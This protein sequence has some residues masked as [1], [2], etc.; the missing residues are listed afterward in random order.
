M[1]W[2]SWLREKLVIY[3][4]NLGF[5]VQKKWEQFRQHQIEISEADKEKVWIKRSFNLQPKK[6]LFAKLKQLKAER[7][8]PEFLGE[9]A[10]GC[11]SEKERKVNALALRADEGRDY[12][13]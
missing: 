7:I 13:R 5:S 6:Q 12:L 9:K 8:F 11:S 10:K 3:L 4:L 2:I 1:N